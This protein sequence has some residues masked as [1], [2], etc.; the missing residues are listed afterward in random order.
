MDK[1]LRTG[2]SWRWAP[3]TRNRFCRRGPAAR[4][5]DQGL[6]EVAGEVGPNVLGKLS[7]SRSTTRMSLIG[8]A[9]S[10]ARGT[11]P[12]AT[13]PAV[14]WAAVPVDAWPRMAAAI[15]STTIVALPVPRRL[16]PDLCDLPGARRLQY[17]ATRKAA[18]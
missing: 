5:E 4:L 17:S 14:L 13:L 9:G 7:F 18:Q 11:V 6:V 1:E 15:A 2:W 12:G 8:P 16:T 3:G 10:A